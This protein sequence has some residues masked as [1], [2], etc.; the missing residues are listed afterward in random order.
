MTTITTTNLGTKPM[1]RLSLIANGSVGKVTHV[2]LSNGNRVLY[3]VFL[4]RLG[5]KLVSH[6]VAQ[7]NVV[8][9]LTI[10]SSDRLRTTN[11]GVREGLFNNALSIRLTNG[12]AVDNTTSVRDRHKDQIVVRPG[13]TRRLRNTTS[14]ANLLMLI[15]AA[16]GRRTKADRDRNDNNTMLRRETTIRFWKRSHSSFV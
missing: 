9:F 8:H 3:I 4:D 5:I 10:I 14:F 16:T 6:G 13:D 12:D 11:Y 15:L 1:R 7:I 2:A